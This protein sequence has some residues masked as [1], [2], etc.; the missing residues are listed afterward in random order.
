MN[1]RNLD[2]SDLLVLLGVLCLAGAVWSALGWVGVLA[3]V[4]A[5]MLVVGL[6]LAMARRDG[7]KG[8]R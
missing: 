5:V 2:L 4:G 1:Y 8:K 6:G 7:D 3:F